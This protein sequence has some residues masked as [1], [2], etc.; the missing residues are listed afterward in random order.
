VSATLGRT[1]ATRRPDGLPGVATLMG[2]LI[3]GCRRRR[4]R[5]RRNHAT[6]VV[7][8]GLGTRHLTEVVHLREEVR[9]A[10]VA[11][12]ARAVNRVEVAHRTAIEV[13]E[14]PRE[15]DQEGTQVAPDRQQRSAPPFWP[16]C[17]RW[18]K[19]SDNKRIT[20]DSAETAI[21]KLVSRST[22]TFRR[23]WPR[24]R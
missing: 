7:G 10:E 9:P 11:V 3:R 15:A 6:G 4:R 2:V 21:A 22:G 24:E 14:V 5:R 23:L 13:A 16:F 1:I 18:E 12:E 20:C 19:C 17:V 8:G